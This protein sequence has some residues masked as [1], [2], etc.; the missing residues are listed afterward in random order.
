MD[1]LLTELNKDQQAL[2]EKLAFSPVEDYP[3]YCSLVG[4]IRGLQRAIRLIE[5]LPDD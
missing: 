1:Y 4:E 3:S 5:D 2:I